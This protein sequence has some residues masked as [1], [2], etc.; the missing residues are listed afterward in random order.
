MNCKW[1]EKELNKSQVYEYIRG[2][3]KGNSCSIRCSQLIKV[4][5][6]IENYNKIH[7]SKCV[8]CNKIFQ[9]KTFSSGMVC[10]IKCQGVLSS[11]RMKVKNPM[12]I[13]EY[14]EKA[15]AR[16]KEINHKPYIQG[17]NGRGATIHQLKLYNELIK[18]ND[19][20]EME[21]IEKTGKLRLKFN[22]P[23]HYKIDIAS[24]ILKLA[25]E[26]DGSSHNTLKIKECDSRKEKL[27]S[28]KGW[29]VLRFTNSQIQKELE[30]CVQMVL[31]MI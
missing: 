30:N 15:S 5:G 2:K 19:S 3:S 31:S 14:R 21:L 24:R 23:R 16:Q 25:I 17:G 27:L 29:K 12:F 20:F 28:L 22:S 26:V 18:Y 1:C 7:E 4:Y 8:V 11:K 13:K 9:R 6:S 10:S